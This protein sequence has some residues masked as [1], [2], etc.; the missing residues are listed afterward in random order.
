MDWILYALAAAG[1]SLVATGS[2]QR[3]ICHPEKRDSVHWTCAGLSTLYAIIN[4]IRAI[5]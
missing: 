2:W 4:F 5:I 3:I 1:W